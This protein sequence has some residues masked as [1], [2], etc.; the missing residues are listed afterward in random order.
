MYPF[1]RDHM[2]DC[3][4]NIII[5]LCVKKENNEWNVN[6]AKYHDLH[7]AMTEQEVYVQTLCFERARKKERDLTQSYDESPNTNRQFKKAK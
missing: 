6:I 4:Y 7:A 3:C 5:C 2:T 1:A